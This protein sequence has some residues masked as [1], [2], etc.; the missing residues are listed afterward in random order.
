MEPDPLTQREFDLWR[1][2]HDHKIDRLVKHIDTQESLNL[3]TE[4][5]IATLEAGESK[6]KRLSI[7]S[8]VT[9]ITTAV[10]AALSA[11]GSNR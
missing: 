11:W 8:V 7:G 4:G 3:R 10:I 5:R 9:A 2:G 6:N 1:D